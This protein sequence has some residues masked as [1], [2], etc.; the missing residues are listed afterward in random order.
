MIKFGQENSFNLHVGVMLKSVNNQQR[1]RANQKQEERVMLIVFYL[2]KN[3][4]KALIGNRIGNVD[5]GRPWELR[6]WPTGSEP[7]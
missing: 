7:P 4:P 5:L 3:G 1:I 6:S 2:Q